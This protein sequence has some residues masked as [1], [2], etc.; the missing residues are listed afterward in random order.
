MASLD[1]LQHAAVRFPGPIVVGTFLNAILHGVLMIQ[2][3]RYYRKFGR[4]DSWWIRALVIFS[5]ALA[6]ASTAVASYCSYTYAII[7]YG[8]IDQI[9]HEI[10][11]LGALIL[12]I[13]VSSV[14]TQ[15]F[16]GWRV[17]KLTGR[18]WLLVVSTTSAVL[19]I[20]FGI[21]AVVFALRESDIRKRTDSK[22]LTLAWLGLAG[23]TNILI[24]VVSLVIL[25]RP[26]TN[27]VLHW[28]S[29]LVFQTGGVATIATVLTIGLYAG[30]ADNTNL[31]IAIV[32]PILH[33]NCLVSSL[34]SREQWPTAQPP[35]TKN[36]RID[37]R[38]PVRPGRLNERLHPE[39]DSNATSTA[40]TATVV[41]I[42]NDTRSEEERSDGQ[43]SW[44]A[45]W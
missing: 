25:K 8:K 3:H 42:Y 20:G 13:C 35:S 11:A 17:K 44:V 39:S 32:W 31:I 33:A 36:R 37:P 14:P 24:T 41:D 22:G 16:F 38:P 29:R 10:P 28:L 26:A 23:F 5:L 34:N 19:Q 18:I 4:T 12:L 7:D 2:C 45:D 27:G 1:E 21:A 30:L 9:L 43:K 15:I 40:T 6:T